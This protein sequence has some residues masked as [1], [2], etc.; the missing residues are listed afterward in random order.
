MPDMHCVLSVHGSY[1]EP[2]HALPLPLPLPA[3]SVF[4]GD[5]EFVHAANHMHANT[6]RIG[7]PQCGASEMPRYPVFA[8]ALI[9]V[10]PAGV[11]VP[12]SVY[13]CTTLPVAVFMTAST[14][15][16]LPDT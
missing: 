10:T 12:V 2:V 14:I 15:T 8:G 11:P 4:A 5:D 13:C 3:A 1:A 6:I 7:P 16:L 9:S